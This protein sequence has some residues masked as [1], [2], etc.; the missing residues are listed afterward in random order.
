MDPN[1]ESMMMVYPP[2]FTI[3]IHQIFDFSRCIIGDMIDE[4]LDRLCFF[5]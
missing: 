5:Q 1:P 2:V 3:L 4:V